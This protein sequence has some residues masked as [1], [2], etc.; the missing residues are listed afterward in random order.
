[1][2]KFVISDRSKIRIETWSIPNSVIKFQ[3]VL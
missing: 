2:K 3:T 1:M